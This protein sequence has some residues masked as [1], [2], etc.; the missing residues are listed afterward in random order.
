LPPYRFVPGVNPHPER[1]GGHGHRW[2]GET[3]P[4]SPDTWHENRLYLYGIDLYHQGYYWESHEA[5][6]GLW[7]QNP[8]GEVPAQFLQGLILNSAAQLKVHAGAAPGARRLSR[9]AVQHLERVQASG[10]CRSD[11]TYMGLG[12]SNLLE[13]MRTHYGPLWENPHERGIRPEGRP[14]L[15]WPA[16][17]N[18][19]HGPR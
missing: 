13:Q 18:W 6:E 5:W 14:P 11:G 7:R 19:P 4:L 17:M 8:R 9:A 3:S 1:P 10:K 12:V 15:L 16:E 2:Q